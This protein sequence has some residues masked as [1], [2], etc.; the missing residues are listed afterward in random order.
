MIDIV[1][2]ME[3]VAH[4]RHPDKT[5]IAPDINLMAHLAIPGRE[6]PLKIH[7]LFVLCVTDRTH[8]TFLSL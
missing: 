3:P 5:T 7:F 2:P 1:A 4:S 8:R 6:E